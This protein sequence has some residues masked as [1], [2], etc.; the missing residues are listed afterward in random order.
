M[1]VEQPPDSGEAAMVL[2]EVEGT[3][4]SQGMFVSTQ[5]GLGKKNHHSEADMQRLRRGR[6][7]GGNEE[8]KRWKGE[9]EGRIR[10]SK[11]VTG[12]GSRGLETGCRVLPL[13]NHRLCAALFIGLYWIR[14]RRSCVCEREKARRGVGARVTAHA[15]RFTWAVLGSGKAARLGVR[16]AE[17]QAVPARPGLQ[18]V[19]GPWTEIAK[20]QQ[21]HHDLRSIPGVDGAR[22]R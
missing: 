3:P 15:T 4:T 16:M 12:A 17:G 22:R 8:K 7:R 13:L 10:V 20:K 2:V 9:C 19:D 21:T 14:R 6:A 11:R 5:L 1:G 18:S